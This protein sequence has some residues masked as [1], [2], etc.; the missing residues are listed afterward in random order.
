ME[1]ENGSVQ[2]NR[3]DV[4]GLRFELLEN[5][6]HTRFVYHNG[7]LLHEEGKESNQTSYHFGAGIEA[8]SRE[9]EMYCYQQN[10]QLSTAFITGRNGTVHNSYQYDAFGNEL[11]TAG[12]LLEERCNGESVRYSYDKAGNRVKKTN[13]EGEIHYFYNA[14]NQ[15]LRE[16]TEKEFTTSGHEMKMM[17][18]FKSKKITS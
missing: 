13:T 14:K 1:T 9:L 17:K 7:E 18:K 11:E 12:Q 10:E 8:F 15:L 2:E 6:K 3:Y 5:G 16:E 4:E